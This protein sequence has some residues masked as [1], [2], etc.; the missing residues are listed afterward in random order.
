MISLSNITKYYSKR[1]YEDFNLEIEERDFVLLSGPSGCGKSSL[2]NIIGM[3]DNEYEGNLTIMGY[4]NPSID[5]KEGRNLLRNDISYLF[6]NYGLMDNKSIFENL[7]IVKLSGT[8]KDK[9]K[10]CNDTLAKLGLNMSLKTPVYELSGGEQ[11]RVAMAKIL[12]KRPKIILCDEPTGS[13]DK[14][15]AK[16]ILELLKE[17]N[18]AGNTIVIASHDDEVAKYA[19]KIVN[20]SSE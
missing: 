16:L 13:L 7:K 4:E 3:L 8:R 10:Q 9:K 19:N 15:N 18:E 17:L 5:S 12:L 1:L 14:E 2:L 20:I 6:Q 11:Q